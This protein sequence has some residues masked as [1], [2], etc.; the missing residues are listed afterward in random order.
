ME[1]PQ[2]KH[3]KIS[4]VMDVAGKKEQIANQKI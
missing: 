4:L 3:T 2:L 1:T